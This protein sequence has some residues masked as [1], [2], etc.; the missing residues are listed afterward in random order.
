MLPVYYLLKL[1]K[2]K[3]K[4]HRLL[5]FPEVSYACSVEYILH[6]IS[7][8]ICGFSL[9]ISSILIGIKVGVLGINQ[10]EQT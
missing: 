5:I 4:A 6:L 2:K 10:I 3:K 1:K 7:G 8:A 9:Y